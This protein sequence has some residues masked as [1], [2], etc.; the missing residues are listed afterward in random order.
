M[1]KSDLLKQADRILQRFDQNGISE[2]I[3][4]L[5]VY[6]G[7]KSSFYKGISKLNPQSFWNTGV[8]DTAR[9]FM[10]GFRNFVENDLHQGI[11]LERKAQVDTVSDFLEQAN[12]LLNSPGVHPAAPCMIIGASLEEFLRNWFEEADL[13]IDGSPSI[14]SYARALREE[15]LINKQDYKDITSWAGLRNDAAH[16]KWS[17]V[18][19]KNRIA[20]ML[21]GVNLF[22]R[23]HIR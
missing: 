16:G 20:L 12:T 3:E 10:Q 6:A 13:K 1:E 5:R 17:D 15:D 9:G 7:E 8:V 23:K 11:S 21:E 18:S 2:A 14:D 4:F 22:I 19:D